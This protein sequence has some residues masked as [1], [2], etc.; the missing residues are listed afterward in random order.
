MDGTITNGTTDVLPRLGLSLDEAAQVLGIGA[1]LLSQL[2]R[3]G[4]FGPRFYPLG[5]RRIVGVDEVRAWLR[6]GCPSRPEWTLIW[7]R[8]RQEAA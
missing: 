3:T 4:E 6:H 2:D 7:Q 8:L 1:T 5:R